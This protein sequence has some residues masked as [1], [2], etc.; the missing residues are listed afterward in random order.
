M[1]SQFLASHRASPRSTTIIANPI[2]G[3]IIAYPD[4]KKSVR[5][6]NGRLELVGWTPSPTTTCVKPIACRARPSR[7]RFL[8][9]SPQSGDEISASFTRFPGS[10]GQPWE[11]VILTPT[12]DFVGTLNQTNRQMIVLIAVLTGLELLLIYFFSRRLSRPI[13]HVSRDCDRSRSLRSRTRRGRHPTLG[14][15]RNCKPP[16]RCS[17]PRCVRSPRSCRWMWCES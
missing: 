5:L 3:T 15:S 9:R 1:L 8:F 4:Q 12:D 2:K 13:E 17:R 14:R 11:V 6:E 10:F 16:L 7:R